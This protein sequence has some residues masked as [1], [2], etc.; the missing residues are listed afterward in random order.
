MSF[1]VLY[2]DANSHGIIVALSLPTD[3]NPIPQQ[4]WRQLRKEEYEYAQNLPQRR[5]ISW[6]GGRI[7]AHTASNILNLDSGPILSDSFGA[8]IASNPNIICSIAHKEDIAVALV[9]QSRFGT[10]GI[11]VEHFVPARPQI[12]SKILRKEEAEYI[13]QL[14]QRQQWLATLLHFSLKEALYKAIHPK[15]KRYV[16]FF[17]VSISPFQ[18]GNAD[19]Q[20][21]LEKEPLPKNTQAQYIWLENHLISTVRC[22]W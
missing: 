1:S 16:S 2:K 10:I 18:N 8:P 7:A 15:Q 12:A 14:P 17:E 21:H 13:S 3:Q 6:V 4:A 20:L 5:Q 11:D 19:I 9:A 22:I